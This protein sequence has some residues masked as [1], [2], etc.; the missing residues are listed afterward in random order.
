MS[1]HRIW[2]G[3]DPGTVLSATF[4]GLFLLAVFIHFFAFRV[5]GYPK[6]TI[7]KYNP[8]AAVAP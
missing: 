1:A 2:I 4:G 6:S 8:P 3:K 7:A 5:T